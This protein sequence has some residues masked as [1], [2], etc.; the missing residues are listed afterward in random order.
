MSHFLATTEKY[1]LN[2]FAVTWELLDDCSFKFINVTFPEN[3]LLL[4]TVLTIFYVVL[5]LLL[6]FTKSLL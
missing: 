3:F 5:A 4:V 1:S 6:D 2:A